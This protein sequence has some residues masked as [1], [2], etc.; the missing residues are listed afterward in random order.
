M[1]RK[2]ELMGGGMVDGWIK[3]LVA[4]WMN[5][6]KNQNNTLNFCWC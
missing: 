1:E 6:G 2:K 4:G 5:R 3:G